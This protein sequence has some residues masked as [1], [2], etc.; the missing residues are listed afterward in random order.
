MCVHACVAACMRCGVCMC[1]FSELLFVCMHVCLR[2]YV[3]ASIC[4]CVHVCLCA[5]VFVCVCVCVHVCLC[6]Y[7][8]VCV[9]VCMHMCT[10]TYLLSYNF[11]R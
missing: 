4:V 7:V 3:F 9:C 2:A 11:F 8:F 10:H 1:Q 5:Y 6:A